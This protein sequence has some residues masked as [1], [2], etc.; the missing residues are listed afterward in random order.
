MRA[1]QL[2]HTE[3]DN[4]AR[5]MVT[6]LRDGHKMAVTNFNLNTNTLQ[7]GGRAVSYDE[8]KNIAGEDAAH[9]VLKYLTLCIHAYGEL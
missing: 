2:K 9:E 1:L 6:R 4:R 5:L 7:V 3:L 8:L